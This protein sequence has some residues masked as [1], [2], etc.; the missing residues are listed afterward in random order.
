MDVELFKMSRLRYER[1][2]M[3]PSDF[4]KSKKVFLVKQIAYKQL[5]NQ[6]ELLSVRIRFSARPGSRMA[7]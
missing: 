7:R 2:E 3:A 6:A 4:L 1:L 5:L